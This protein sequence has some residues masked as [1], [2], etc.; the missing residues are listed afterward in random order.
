MEEP[1]KNDSRLD[2]VQIRRKDGEPTPVAV[3]AEWMLRLLSG[4]DIEGYAVKVVSEA[5]KEAA[6]DP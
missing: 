5:N 3:L 6:Q 1:M 2:N 4:G